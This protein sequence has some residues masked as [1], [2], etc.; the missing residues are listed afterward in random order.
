MSYKPQVIADSSGK[1]IGNMLR[2]ASAAE[3]AGYVK[4]LAGR[5]TAVRDTR[6]VY[7]TDPVNAQWAAG[8]LL[9]KQDPGI[10]I[11]AVEARKP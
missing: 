5:W 7:C 4:D 2:F 1:F 11:S 10:P 8:R 6:V 3:A 9:W